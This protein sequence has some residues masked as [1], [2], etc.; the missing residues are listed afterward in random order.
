MQYLHGFML[1]SHHEEEEI[2]PVTT[3][4]LQKDWVC[5]PLLYCINLFVPSA[6]PTFLHYICK[7][8]PF[9]WVPFHTHTQ[10]R[11]P[12]AVKEVWQR[13]LD[14]FIT[15]LNPTQAAQE[16]VSKSTTDL[17]HLSQIFP[18]ALLAVFVVP[19]LQENVAVSESTTS[20]GLQPKILWLHYGMDYTRMPFDWIIS[21][22][23]L[24]P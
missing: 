9:N 4:V 6:E 5:Q 22:W 2:I 8:H 3:G 17:V 13:I 10:K 24:S 21:S 14:G 7:A 20:R 19:V 11:N 1:A 23:V 18:L 16:G 12:F 15:T